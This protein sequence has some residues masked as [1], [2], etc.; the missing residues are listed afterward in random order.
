MRMIMNQCKAFIIY[1][2][3]SAIGQ[4]I[5]IYSSSSTLLAADLHLHVAAPYFAVVLLLSA[6]MLTPLSAGR[7]LSSEK[8]HGL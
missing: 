8:H 2:S 7:H 3:T 1:S 4:E 6:G 5:I